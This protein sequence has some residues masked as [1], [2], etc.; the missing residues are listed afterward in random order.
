MWGQLTGSQGPSAHTVPHTIHEV[1]AGR[2]WSHVVRRHGVTSPA[3]DIP[4]LFIASL[5][6]PVA[7]LKPPGQIIRLQLVAMDWLVGMIF[8]LLCDPVVGGFAKSQNIQ[9]STPKIDSS[10]DGDSN[11]VYAS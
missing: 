4:H 6:Q 8:E 7:E 3:Q 5:R 2:A 10:Q 9:H 1:W 11:E